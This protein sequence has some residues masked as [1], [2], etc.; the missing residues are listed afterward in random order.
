[1]GIKE[2]M[3]K[4]GW[5]KLPNFNKLSLDVYKTQNIIHHN[6]KRPRQ[7]AVKQNSLHF[8]LRMSLKPISW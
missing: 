4:V 8:T 2:F 3:L 7:E 5:K 6:S 1:M